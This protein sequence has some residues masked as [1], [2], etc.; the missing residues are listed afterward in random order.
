MDLN[1]TPSLKMI[2]VENEAVGQASVNA[3]FIHDTCEM[4]SQEFEKESSLPESYFFL[5]NANI[6]KTYTTAEPVGAVFFIK[7]GDEEA[8]IVSFVKVMQN[9]PDV[10]NLISE[11]VKRMV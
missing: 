9:R 6:G 5:G 8:L 4:L 7:D 2:Q 1:R 3:A 10:F 11:A